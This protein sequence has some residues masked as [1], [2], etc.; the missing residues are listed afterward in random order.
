MELKFLMVGIVYMMESQLVRLKKS[1]TPSALDELH[2][3]SIRISKWR[4]NFALFGKMELNI[5][6]SAVI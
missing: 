6:W 4:N 1:S 3:Y 2:P 5:K